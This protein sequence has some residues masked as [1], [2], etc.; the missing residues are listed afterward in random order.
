MEALRDV[1]MHRPQDLLA[2][3]E[4]A[5][6]ERLGLEVRAFGPVAL[7]EAI[8]A[9]RNVRVY[10]PQGLLADVEGANT[11]RLGLGVRALSLVKLGEIAEVLRDIGMHRPQHF[12]A[13]R[14]GSLRNGNRLSKLALVVELLDQL[15]ESAGLVEDCSLGGPR[16]CMRELHAADHNR[17][18]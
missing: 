14:E 16:L 5:D 12:L 15:I 11:E 2:D 17:D 9:L 4:R 3:V 10:R 7:R 18:Q 13:E 1:R 8:E 6:I